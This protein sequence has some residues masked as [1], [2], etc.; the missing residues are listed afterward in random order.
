ML[1]G[2]G[3]MEVGE[4]G[5]K[6]VVKGFEV[7]RLDPYSALYKRVFEQL[8]NPKLGRGLHDAGGWRELKEVEGDLRSAA[9]GAGE[10]EKDVD[11]VSR[12]VREGGAGSV[13]RWRG[14]IDR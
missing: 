14:I 8:L 7:S 4:I 13:R 10:C 11:E 12:R 6:R 5:G 9:K 2:R 3:R 1:K